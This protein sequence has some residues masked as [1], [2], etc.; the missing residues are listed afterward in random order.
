MIGTQVQYLG[1]ME[2]EECSSRFKDRRPD[3]GTTSMDILA[4]VC[5][6]ACS[7]HPDPI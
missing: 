6:V 7:G 5:F 3:T 1:D 2:K 4:G